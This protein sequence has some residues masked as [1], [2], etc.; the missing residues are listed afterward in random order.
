MFVQV[1]PAAH[2][3]AGYIKHHEIRKRGK[4]VPGKTLAV[5][6]EPIKLSSGRPPAVMLPA[7]QRDAGYPTAPL[8]DGGPERSREILAC[9]D[10]TGV[11]EAHRQ[12]DLPVAHLMQSEA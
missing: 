11:V 12:E 4:Q 5:A 7:L 3:G 6:P 2:P 9:G 10:R 1:Q 8:P